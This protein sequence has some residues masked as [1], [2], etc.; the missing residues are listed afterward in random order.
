M[1]AIVQNRYGSPDVLELHEIDEPVA[2][3]DRM[4]IRVRA[5]SVHADAAIGEVSLVA[6]RLIKAVPVRE[7]KTLVPAVAA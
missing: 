1:K 7:R 3:G 4:L 2:G 6:W 5:A